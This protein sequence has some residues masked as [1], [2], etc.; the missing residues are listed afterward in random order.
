MLVALVAHSSV[1]RPTAFVR[2]DQLFQRRAGAE[3]GR[4]DSTWKMRTHRGDKLN[5]SGAQLYFT[6]EQLLF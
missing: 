1:R 2:R 4:S 5:L 6:E 3:S